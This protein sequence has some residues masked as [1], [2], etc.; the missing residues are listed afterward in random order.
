MSKYFGRRRGSR[1]GSLDVSTHLTNLEDRLTEKTKLI[2][3]MKKFV[4]LDAEAPGLIVL[5]FPGSGKSTV[6]EALS[7]VPLPRSAS[8]SAARKMI[9]IKIQSD[10]TCV[11]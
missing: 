7:N 5:G 9:R 1:D 10:P 2:D 6:I 3:E 8:G 11:K 4:P